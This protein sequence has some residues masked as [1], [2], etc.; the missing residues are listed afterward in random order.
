MRPLVADDA[1]GLF[2]PTTAALSSVTVAFDRAA[3]EGETPAVCDTFGE[4]FFEGDSSTESFAVGSP[5]CGFISFSVLASRTVQN[6]I[7]SELAIIVA[8]VP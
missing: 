8:A 2:E 3:G 6:A 4:T 1:N 5:S 7:F